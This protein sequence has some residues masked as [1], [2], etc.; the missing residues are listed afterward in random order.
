MI[1]D[2]LKQNGWDKLHVHG[3]KS[4]A[5]VVLH[6]FTPQRDRKMVALLQSINV[7]TFGSHLGCHI[8]FLEIPKEDRIQSDSKCTGRWSQA[9]EYVKIF[10]MHS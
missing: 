10:C 1:I 7:S 4:A 6:C 9:L 8:D 3:P 2:A 5:Y